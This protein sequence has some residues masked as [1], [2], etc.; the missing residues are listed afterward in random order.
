MNNLLLGGVE[1][2]PEN[3][4][5]CL[6]FSFIIS[7]LLGV[8]TSHPKQEARICYLLNLWWSL[9]DPPHEESGPLDWSA[10]VVSSFRFDDLDLKDLSREKV[11]ENLMSSSQTPR[12]V[13]KNWIERRFAP[14]TSS[15]M[16]YG[17]TCSETADDSLKEVNFKIADE[18]VSVKT[19]KLNWLLFQSFF[20]NKAV[21]LHW[22]WQDRVCP[23]S[24][25]RSNQSNWG[26]EFA[27]SR[28]LWGCWW[29]ISGTGL[30]IGLV[31]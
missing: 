4:L 6:M 5:G 20:T 29:I 21:L 27:F 23:L 22:E 30:L 10:P 1:F 24:N 11:A 17:L 7:C 13:W 28:R 15:S 14:S 25:L 19:K 9:Q 16:S 3:G 12:S 18:S 2:L 8:T 31:R 26:S